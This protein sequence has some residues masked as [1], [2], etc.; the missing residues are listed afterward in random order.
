MS[1]RWKDYRAKGRTR[2]KTVTL[3]P[4][5]FIRRFLLHILPAG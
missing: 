4:E 3:K 1:F 5:E 2:Y